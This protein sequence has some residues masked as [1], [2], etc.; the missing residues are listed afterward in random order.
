MR[1][2][3]VMIDTELAT[4]FES[5]VP[6]KVVAPRIIIIGR[7]RARYSKMVG[8][9]RSSRN[10]QECTAS[11]ALQQSEIRYSCPTHFVKALRSRV[12]VGMPVCE[13]DQLG[14]AVGA[15]LFCMWPHKAE[16]PSAN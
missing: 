11:G 8:E 7:S 16:T 15:F 5:S 2:C 1:H 12:G 10:M 14:S 4:P 6:F 3:C 9:R 13:G